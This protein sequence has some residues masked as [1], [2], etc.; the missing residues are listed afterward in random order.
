MTTAI[1]FSFILGQASPVGLLKRFVC[2]GAFPH[3]LLFTGNA[4]VGKKT[5]ATAFAMACNCL[6]LSNRKDRTDAVFPGPDHSEPAML[7]SDASTS[8]ALDPS[9]ADACGECKSCRKIAEGLHPDIISIA[10]H[11]SVIRIDQIRTLLRTLSLRPHEARQ[12]VVILSDAQALNPEAANALLKILEE[13][14]P[15]TLMILTAVEAA[16][17][18]PTV[19]SR[20]QQ[21]RFMPLNESVIETL[22][23]TRD[24]IDPETARKVA[25]LCGG[26]YTR[27][28]TLLDLGWQSRR[29]WVIRVMDRLTGDRDTDLRAWLLFSEKL[30]ARKEWIEDTLDTLLMWLRDLVVADIDPSQ[31]L[32]R[33]PLS[34]CRD[35]APKKHLKHRL[36]QMEAVLEA[37]AALLANANARLTLDAM[38]LKMIGKLNSTQNVSP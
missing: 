21:V 23:T 4:G 37:K 26:S 11:A 22:L 31:V 18:L 20:C 36:R 16:D 1:G 34:H 32:G 6:A 3:A 7:N 2:R 25:P 13:P 8:D 12:R 27:A 35:S 15:R 5:A 24:G 30:A 19:V 38:L 33:D 17:L 10:P 29:N 28:K 14:P 9:M